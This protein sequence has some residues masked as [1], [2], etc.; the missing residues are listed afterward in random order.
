MIPL[1]RWRRWLLGGAPILA[2]SAAAH[3]GLTV[4]ALLMWTTLGVLPLSRQPLSQQKRPILHRLF[5]AICLGGCIPAPAAVCCR[6]LPLP[7][8]LPLLIGAACLGAI[9]GERVLLRAPPKWAAA[10]AGI[11]L[12][13]GWAALAFFIADT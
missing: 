10:A 8:R 2:L 5:F 1:A 9:A 13:T 6:A 7:E 4:P 3:P 11:I 12:L